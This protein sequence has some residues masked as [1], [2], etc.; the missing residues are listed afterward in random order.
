MRRLLAGVVAA[1]VLCVMV[2][3]APPSPQRRYEKRT[4]AFVFDE[5]EVGTLTESEWYAGS[6][7]PGFH[8]QLLPIRAD[9]MAEMIQS[10]EAL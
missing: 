1:G 10:G 9:F 5:D 4:T 3:P 6:C 8:R 2:G 7:W